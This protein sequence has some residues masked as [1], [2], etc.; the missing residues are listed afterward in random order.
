MHFLM[1]SLSL[2]LHPDI[3]FLI[4]PTEYKLVLWKPS[5]SPNR[6]P[7]KPDGKEKHRK[8]RVCAAAL[9]LLSDFLQSGARGPGLIF[10]A[11]PKQATAT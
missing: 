10:L 4:F 11:A 1:L 7:W 2:F 3:W 6:V 8:W 5:P 9:G